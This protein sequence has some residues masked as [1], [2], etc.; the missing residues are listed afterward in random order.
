MAK[1]RWWQSYLKNEIE[2]AKKQEANPLLFSSNTSIPNLDAY[3]NGF[4][5]TGQY[6]DAL[7]ASS[8][9]HYSFSNKEREE[10]EFLIKL[11]SETLNKIK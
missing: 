5:V 7:S 3:S 6:I 8:V 10:L 1:N 2:N 11:Y 9:T 4:Q